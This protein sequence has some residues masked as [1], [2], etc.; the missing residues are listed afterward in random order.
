M[1]S[2]NVTVLLVLLGLLLGRPAGY[3]FVRIHI[4]ATD[5]DVVVAWPAASI[6]VPYVINEQGMPDVSDGS[7]FD[8]IT[9]SFQAWQDV[10][11]SSLSF[12]YEGPTD[13]E[14]ANSSDGVNLISFVDDATFAMLP[15]GVIA[16]CIPR[17]DN[18]SGDIL[19]A[20]II[21]SPDLDF[22]TT[23]DPDA[24]DVQS[25]AT[26]EI[27][28]LL[29]LDHIANLASTMY[30]Y[31]TLGE[32]APRSLEQDDRAG[33]SAIYP[34]S[35]FAM[36]TGSLSGTITSEGL[37]VFAGH[38][39]AVDS[40]GRPSVSTIIDELDGTYSIVGLP[41]GSYTVYVEPLDGP[42]T[43]ANLFGGVF[44]NPFDDDFHTRFYGDTIQPGS[45]AVVAV[46]AGGG[47]SNIN[48]DTTDAPSLNLT[49]LG[50]GPAGSLAPDFG[51]TAVAVQPGDTLDLGVG[52]DGVASGVGLTFSNPGVTITAGPTFGSMGATP[53][54]IVTLSIAESATTGA[55]NIMVSDGSEISM[56]TGGLLIG[57]QSAV[58]TIDTM[59][60]ANFGDGS[61]S[62]IDA[63]THT[64]GSAIPVGAG[65][66]DIAILPD[67]S[68]AYVSNHLDGTVSVVDLTQG[69]VAATISVGNLPTGV[70]A[71][72]DS[73]TVYVADSG[74][75][76]V[77][78][79]DVASGAVEERLRVGRY[80]EGLD[81]TPNGKLLYVAVSGKK[82]IQ[83]IKTKNHKK[84]RRIKVGRGPLDVSISPDG[85]TACVSLGY[86][87]QV[88]ILDV[89]GGEEVGKVRVR[90]PAFP[91]GLCYSHDGAWAYV[92]SGYGEGGLT[93][94]D[95][96]SQR[97][98]RQ[99]DV[100]A[101]PQGV[102]VG[103]DGTTVYVTNVEDDTVS[104]IDTTVEDD[105]E[106]ADALIATITV[107]D[108]PM[109]IATRPLPTILGFSPRSVP[110]GG[111]VQILGRYFSPDVAGNVVAFGAEIA[112]VTKAS[113]AAVTATVP[114]TVPFPATVSVVVTAHGVPSNPVEFR[115]ATIEPP[116]VKKFQVGA[117]DGYIDVEWLAPTGFYDGI[118]LA[119]GT[120]MFP[121][122]KPGEGP[123]VDPD[124]GQA[125]PGAPSTP[126]DS[127]YT[128]PSVTNGEVRFF[129]IWTYRGLEV[130]EPHFAQC[131]AVAGGDGINDDESFF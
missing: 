56:L 82:W 31:G 3:G 68:A 98:E 44:D 103:R 97:R 73:E 120:K 125:A 75:G 22:D 80:P 93:V 63:A 100:G 38:V 128:L 55:T 81:I 12:D 106:E 74:D 49:L 33:V 118:L 124:T 89:L 72:P 129:S 42:M 59:Y 14:Q 117:G 47:A 40:S 6:P 126:A 112:E 23:G 92:V 66:Y 45:A 131:T 119:V 58:S 5:D 1:R 9:N 2:R 111:S 69:V 54:M 7:D 50:Q 109:G 88:S 130:S 102:A 30:P 107:G 115:V 71:A 90:N 29:G 4:G 48:I 57:E 37:P 121:R 15:P 78:V 86:K 122:L 18:T 11:T 34:N 94:I 62:V 27:G 123:V 53:V 61:L 8:A 108:S 83:P 25:V 36:T 51:V 91:R 127:R 85:E 79:I 39:V 26:H 21:F 105:D 60:V 24:F 77:S 113:V 99:F 43:D 96:G 16:V 32:T 84:K 67:G 41:A 52:G 28:H 116:K 13:L 70:V 114:L 65:P 101:W 64:V 87:N 35:T 110:P 104:V 17:F 20:D 76:R 10:G 46:T 19:D 95:V